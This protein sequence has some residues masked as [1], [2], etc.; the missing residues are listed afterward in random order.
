MNP[1]LRTVGL[2]FP[3]TLGLLVAPLAAEAQDKAL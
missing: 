1:W 2:I 3:L